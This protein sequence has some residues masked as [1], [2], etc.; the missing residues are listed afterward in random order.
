MVG[1][2]ANNGRIRSAFP[3]AN[4]SKD[5]TPDSAPVSTAGSECGQV[6]FTREDVEALLN[7][8]IKY[9]SKFNYK[10]RC[11]NMM[12]YIKRL[13]LCI[14]WFQE[15]ELDYA[16]E[17]EKL[18]N[19]LVLNEKHCTDM[20]ASLKHK[21]E[22]LNMII[23]ELRKNFE[24]AQIQLAKEQTEKLAAN[25]SLVKEKEA[26]HA[27][28]KAQSG[29]TEELGKAQ[30]ELQ[31]ANQR[32][33]SV[34]DMYKLLQEYNSSLQLYNSKLQGDLDE[35]HETIKR[36]EKERTEIASQDDIM[37]QKAE[38][39]NEVA[40]LK[41]ELQQAKD[42]RD[43]H[44]T[45]LKTLQTEANKYN[46]FKDTITEL[47]TTCS[48]QSNQ[49]QELQDRLV[50]CDRRLQMSDLTTFEKMNEFED[51]KQTIIDLK[52]RV[53]EAELKLV[54]GEKLRK[55]LHNTILELKGN[56]RVFCRVRPLLPGE[57]NGDEGKTISYPASLELLGR[58][59]DLMQ[60]AQ[61]HSFTFDKV[62]LP[63]TTQ[64]D[65]F[66]EIS[67]LVQSAL[68][69]YK[70]CIFAYGQ[71]GSGKT[72]TM[73]GK[74]GNAEEKGLIPRCL[75]QIFETRQSLRS[76][77]WKYELQVS[78]L[79]I[80]NET[81][82]D[83]LSTNKE[84]VRTDN[85]VSPQKHAIKHD[86]HGNTHV[87]ELTILDVKSSREVSFLLDHAARNRSVGKT[88]MNEQSSRSHFVF[89]LRISGVNESTEQQVQGVCIF[90]YGQTGSGKTYTMMGKPGN[91]EEKGL[92][93]R[94]L[95]QIFETRQSLRS[96]G[97][98][99]ELQ[100]SMLEIYNETIRDLLSTNKEAVRTD[101]GVSPQ[102]HAIKHDAHGN[103]HVAELTI[104]DVKSS[105]EVSFLLDHAARNRSVGKTQMNEQSSRS[106]FVFTLRISGVNEST[107][108]QVQGVLNLIDLAGS[109][110][111]SKSGSTGDRLKETQAINKSLSSLGDVIFALAKK[112]DHVP[113]RNSKLTYLLQPCLGGDSKT[114]MFVNIAPESSS[115]G[116]SLCSLRFAARVNACEI[117]TP[118]F[119]FLSGVH[120]INFSLLLISEPGVCIFAY[121]Q[122][123]SGKTY[124]M[125]GKPGNAEEKGLIPR[126][127]EQIFETR[128]SL[129]S[130]G[131]KYE[132]QVSMLEIY[133]ETIR[134][135]LST[136][137]EAVRTDNG[138]SPQKH[139]IKHDAH[140]N[141][142][143][144]ELTIL[145]VKSSREVSF[146]LDHAARNRSVGKTQM[147]EQSSRS[148][149]VFTLRISGVNESTEQQVQGVLNLIDLAGSERLSKSGSTGD[150][151][152]ETQAI[153]KSLSSLGDVIFALAKKD[154]HV[155]FRNSKLTYL[156]QP[157]LGGDSKTLMF[158]NIAPESSSTGESL[159]SLRFAARVN[160]CE[161]GTPRRQTNIVKPLDRLSLG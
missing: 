58:G 37:K 108:Q 14:R 33:Q 35:A 9:K 78:M 133:N 5:L 148:H 115:T 81:I 19:A 110:R 112:D 96:Q 136:N 143:V 98:K 44:L 157:C 82:R 7:E 60:N 66:I 113:F 104:L 18:K 91:A 99:Y 53:E 88:Q 45:E 72:Y 83:L 75:E 15:L 29:L 114:L 109:E 24:S 63:N 47:E 16:F 130:Q 87:A 36:G 139:A 140:G 129:R 160:A 55:K 2:M 20:E 4:G 62:F 126:C 152:K 42:E 146:L 61:K 86:A 31:T 138:V 128:Q 70:V 76:Q 17:Q 49:I 159:C 131:W 73:M 116:E 68:D 144:A 21:E 11:E 25:D 38:L 121:G 84:A 52:S 48:S 90:A 85:G 26:R 132:L 79:E 153:N 95:E 135:L 103:T 22:E 32:I 120:N 117:G 154:D 122:T 6:E 111:L 92:I 57:N 134:D 3:V 43:Y 10:E 40:S 23:E 67:Q 124:T 106:H 156:L 145:D 13:R 161:I 71:T 74:P 41:V 89:T 54:E 39:V 137:K 118:R 97:W 149:F 102:K 147:N 69:G 123:G 28:E 80:Y 142:H 155:P 125:M 94:C 105:R 107:E 59:I 158:V 34:N 101:N 8:R 1:T 56:I 93:P 150:R 46:D 141:T 119:F 151:L 127:L 51:Q 12:E 65:V 64:E 27:V 77:G 100:V 30:G 50:S